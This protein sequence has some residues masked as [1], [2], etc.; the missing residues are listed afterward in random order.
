MNEYMERLIGTVVVFVRNGRYVIRPTSHNSLGIEFKGNH[1]SGGLYDDLSP[2]D[3]SSAL[4]E[5]YSSLEEMTEEEAYGRRDSHPVDDGIAKEL[6]L[7][8]WK[9]MA[10]SKDCLMFS[11]GRGPRNLGGFALRFPDYRRSHGITSTTAGDML[12]L[13]F[14]PMENP[15]DQ[16]LV[17]QAWENLRL[18]VERMKKFVDEQR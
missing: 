10:K 4:A 12:G 5:S 7:E 11:F 18:A 13:D 2:D 3:L 14:A 6:G 15:S 16:E 8:N 1:Y 17:L 9:L